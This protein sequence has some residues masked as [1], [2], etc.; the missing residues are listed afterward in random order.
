MTLPAFGFD[1]APYAGGKPV[2]SADLK[3]CPED[4]IVEEVLGFEPDGEG[5]HLFLQLQTD[6]Q[7]TRHTLKLL[8]RH[9]GVSPKLV[10]YS[11]LKD[12][13]GLTSQWFSLHLPGRNVEVDAAALA[14][15]GITYLRHSRH[16]KKLRVGTHKANRFHIRLR[17]CTDIGE[18]EARAATVIARGVPNYF[19]PQRFGHGGANVDEALYWV[20]SRQL[21]SEREKRSRVLS[22]LRAWLFNGELARRIDADTWNC[23][24][25]GDPVA[26]SGSQSFFMPDAWDDILQRRLAEGDIHIAGRL[27]SPDYQGTASDAINAYL[28][29]AGFSDATRPLRLLPREFQLESGAG[30]VMLSF[31]LPAGAYATSVV[32]ELVQAIDKSPAGR[33]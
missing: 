24:L 26:L 11:G 33:P 16:G 20:E 17:N 6:D 4:F 31:N 22:V 14:E 27:W 13:R 5:E 8:A 19:G 21:P 18:V 9:F 32:R 23:W 3:T 2:V 29:S 12:R 7:N 15:Q 30:V 1:D 28:A 25:P 10:S